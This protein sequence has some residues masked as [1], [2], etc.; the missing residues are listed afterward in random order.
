MQFHS[1][2]SAEQYLRENDYVNV[3]GRL[4]ERYDIT[5][6]ERA[7]LSQESSIWKL[8]FNPILTETRT[9]SEKI[10]EHFK[11]IKNK[12]SD[13]FELPESNQKATIELLPNDLIYNGLNY[14][15]TF[16]S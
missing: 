12:I 6:T 1:Q 10:L 3:S 5:L 9:K 11:F 2:S 16:Y 15:I 14:R 8:E 13:I 7:I 4:L